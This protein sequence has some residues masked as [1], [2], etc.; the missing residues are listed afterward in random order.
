[1]RD[2]TA[3]RPAHAAR[4]CSQRVQ[5]SVVAMGAH[6]AEPTLSC[7]EAQLADFSVTRYAR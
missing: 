7:G 3:I 4:I 2:D 1:M 5:S 6:S